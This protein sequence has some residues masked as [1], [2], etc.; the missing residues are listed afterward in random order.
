MA[1]S[2]KKLE[3]HDQIEQIRQLSFEK[4]CLI[5]KHSHRC[6]ICSIALYRLEDDW[7]FQPE[8][9]ETFFL[10]VIEYRPVSMEVANVFEVHHES[11]QVLLILNG[12][13]VYDASHLDI[14]F[15]ELNEQLQ[16][17]QA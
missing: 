12:E 5:Y 14:S 11:P 17:A 13:C 7:T 6:N 1:I 4:P 2:W 10:D 3:A 16:A 9:M 8:E 15:Q